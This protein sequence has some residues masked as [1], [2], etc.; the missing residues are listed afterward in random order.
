MLLH[1]GNM[2]LH[3]DFTAGPAAV[4]D[5]VQQG[6]Q[7]DRHAAGMPL[8]HAHR[9][10]PQVTRG[11]SFVVFLSAGAETCALET[12]SFSKYAGF[13]GTRLGWTVIP[14]AL[15]FADG[16]KVQVIIGQH[17]ARCTSMRLRHQD[18]AS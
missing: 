1:A 3:T 16:S 13:T 5:R 11:T 8:Q 2:K 4:F 6:R 9:V 17:F 10:H 12:C 18:G 14:D 15:K 7:R